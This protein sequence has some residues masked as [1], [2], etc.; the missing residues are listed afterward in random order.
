[1]HIQTLTLTHYRGAR[2]LTLDL[3][4]RLNVLVGVN[5]V[6]KSTVLDAAALAL[7]WVV[8]RIR[9]AGTSGRPIVEADIMNHKASASVEIVC[10]NQEQ[11]VAWRV[12]KGRKGYGVPSHPTELTQ[13]NEYTQQIQAQIAA[14]NQQVNLPL[15]VHYPVHRAV[16]D[17]PLR[18]RERHRFGLLEAYDDALTTGADFRKFFEWFREQEDLENE[19]LVR[20]L[21]LFK[22]VPQEILFAA[23][24]QDPQLR[25]VRNALSRLLPEFK[26]LTVRRSPLR[27]EV[28]KQGQVLTI[29]QLSDGEKCVIAMVSDL[30]RRIAI[31]NPL[32]TDP[33]TGEG[34]ILIDEIDL[35]LH[36][37]W[38]RRI[39]PRLVEVFPNCQ[40]ILSTHSPHVLTHVQ[41]ENIV[42]LDWS[43]EGITASKPAESYGKTVNRI[44]EDL[45][46]LETTR[47]EPIDAAI[48]RL[49]QLIDRGELDQAKQTIDEIKAAMG[50]TDPDLVKAE[51]LI[52]RKEL[53]GK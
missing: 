17:I 21:P 29:N 42:L 20:K 23:D 6:G 33:L 43:A 3:D 51:V 15:F 24:H 4:S 40:F 16:L 13:L 26:N 31:A 38:Q 44:L 1:M 50:Q 47:P 2:A 36:P 41:P 12:T 25:A 9:Q 18:I 28:E 45:M 34:V 49:Y 14:S 37:K 11:S 39:V 22:A 32:R 19:D 27:M 46:G 53:I 8:S 30:A 10:L 35:H 7:S 5:G 52:K 48:Q